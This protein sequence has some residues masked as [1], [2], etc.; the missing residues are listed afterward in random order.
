M[1]CFK[2]SPILNEVEFRRAIPRRTDGLP[3]DLAAAMAIEPTVTELV[4]PDS[5]IGA[6]FVVHTAVLPMGKRPVLFKPDGRMPYEMG[7]GHVDCCYV[8]TSWPPRCPGQTI[9]EKCISHDAWD[10]EVDKYCAFCCSYL[11]VFSVPCVR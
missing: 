1:R 10:A 7:H 11:G 4:K 2:E 6:L 5:I 9:D 3:V 8:K